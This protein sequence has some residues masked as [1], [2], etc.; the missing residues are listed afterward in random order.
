MTRDRC[1]SKREINETSSIIRPKWYD[2]RSSY[3]SP[4]RRDKR[5]R[6][7]MNEL[8]EIVKEGV[9]MRKNIYV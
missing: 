7:V 4:N 6:S 1:P 9:K 2:K 8:S 3:I 5:N